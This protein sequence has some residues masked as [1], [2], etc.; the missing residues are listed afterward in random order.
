MHRLSGS[1]YCFNHDSSVAAERALSRRR[2]GLHRRTGKPSSDGA[3]PPRLRTIEEIQA[4]LE[5]AY[6]DASA[7]ENSSQRSRT[8]GYLLQ[9]AVRLIEVGEL[10]SRLAALETASGTNQRRMAS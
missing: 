4:E 1:L 5:R 8:L 6:L 10:E 9:V 7:L 2:G 3:T